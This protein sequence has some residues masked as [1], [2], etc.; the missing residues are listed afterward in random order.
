[1]AATLEAA[2]TDGIHLVGFATTVAS[3]LGHSW[4]GSVYGTTVGLTLIGLS[5]FTARRHPCVLPAW[6]GVAG[7]VLLVL[8]QWNTWLDSPAWGA[9]DTADVAR[10]A[11]IFVTLELASAGVRWRRQGRPPTPDWIAT[12]ADGADP[13]RLRSPR[14]LRQRSRSRGSITGSD[15]AGSPREPS[16]TRAATSHELLPLARRARRTPA[17]VFGVWAPG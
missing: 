12:G 9:F 14:R 17:G 8:T 15:I 4:V 13:Y 6:L 11:V 3:A 2:V 5:A 16:P 10:A 7:S 1:V